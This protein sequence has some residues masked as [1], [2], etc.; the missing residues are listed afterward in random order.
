MFI[1]EHVVYSRACSE[2]DITSPG[3]IGSV[4][5]KTTLSGTA[6]I[7]KGPH[8]ISVKLETYSNAL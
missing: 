4:I 3:Y 7:K 2:T 1:P 6:R 8:H 5:E